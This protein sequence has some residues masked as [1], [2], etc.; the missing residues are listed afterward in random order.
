MGMKQGLYSTLNS[1]SSASV[2]DQIEMR[3][4]ID[5][6]QMIGHIEND[7]YVNNFEV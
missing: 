1:W 7:G 2:P 6:R 4:S 3:E 5:L